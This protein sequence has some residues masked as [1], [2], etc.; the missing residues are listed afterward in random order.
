MDY[1]GIVVTW[2]NVY[3]AETPGTRTL[4]NATIILGPEDELQPDASLSILTEFG[5]QTRPEGCT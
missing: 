1:H 4:D 3:R 2:L 5:G